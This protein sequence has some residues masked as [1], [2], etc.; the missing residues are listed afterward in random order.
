MDVTRGHYDY[1]TLKRTAIELVHKYNPE[2]VLIEDASTGTALGQEL[3]ELQKKHF[4]LSVKLVPI[5]RDKIGRLFVHQAKF[6]AGE[7]FFPR[8]APFMPTF[9]AELL[10]FPQSRYDD[11]VDSLTQA[12]SLQIG[13]DTTYKW[14]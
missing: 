4:R 8:N 1:P 14:C 9:L 2:F 12:L 3:Q 6:E 5:E 11:Q 13:Y 10:T 7:I